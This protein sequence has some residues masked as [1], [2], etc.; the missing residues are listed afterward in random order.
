V[1]FSYLLFCG[2]NLAQLGGEQFN[3]NDSRISHK[4]T[5]AAKFFL[6]HSGIEEPFTVR[7]F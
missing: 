1:S 5:R 3:K 4:A 7:N 2:A 6:K